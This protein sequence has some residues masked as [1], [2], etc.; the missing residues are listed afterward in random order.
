MPDKLIQCCLANYLDVNSV[1]T[2]LV[3]TINKQT[4][5]QGQVNDPSDDMQNKSKMQK[6]FIDALIKLSFDYIQYIKFRHR[7]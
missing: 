6:R 7:N 5:I 4:C 2:K 3:M 1:M